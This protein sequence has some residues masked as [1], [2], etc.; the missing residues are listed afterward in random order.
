MR[1]VVSLE[2]TTFTMLVNKCQVIEDCN[3]RTTGNVFGR[4]NFP[5][6]GR[7]KPFAPRGQPFKPGGPFGSCFPGNRGN[8][9]G[10][11]LYAGGRSGGPSGIR[12]GGPT[13]YSC[14]KLGHISST[15]LAKGD[16]G[17]GRPQQQGRVYAMTAE[18]ASKTD[19]DRP[20]ELGLKIFCLKY[21]LHVH[22]HTPSS[23]MEVSRL[24]CNQGCAR[25]ESDMADFSI[26]SAQ[27]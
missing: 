24:G 27:V 18:N 11:G 13:C 19:F 10:G 25:T 7:G 26:R 4:G 15:C 12:A 9:R 3:K 22:V 16:H 21:D 2:I 8:G 6:R 20:H 17:G 5:G 1:V 23:G 14:G